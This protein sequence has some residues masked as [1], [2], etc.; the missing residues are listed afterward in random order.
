[1]TWEGRF[2]VASSVALVLAVV[3]TVMTVA[4]RADAIAV[5]SVLVTL[6]IPL[7]LI[8]LSIVGLGALGGLMDRPAASRVGSNPFPHMH[9]GERFCVHCGAKMA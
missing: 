8:T 4:L 5:V 6:W 1:M 2:T 3:L 9:A 7:L